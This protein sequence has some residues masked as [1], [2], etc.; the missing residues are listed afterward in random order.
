MFDYTT[1]LP[2]MEDYLKVRIAYGED[3]TGWAAQLDGEY[4]C[5]ANLP[6]RGG[7]MLYDIV[8]LDRT[9]EGLPAVAE[10]V[11]HYFAQQCCVEY[12]PQAEQDDAAACTASYAR[13]RAACVAAGCAVE[14][15]VRGIAMLNAPAGLDV[16]GLLDS[17][18]IPAEAMDVYRAE[19]EDNGDA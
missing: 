12:M 14:G 9:Q 4:V 8:T 2:H 3:E 18:G 19:E 17:L 11:Q 15:L 5:L 10:V 16:V 1:L 13:F 6:L 7:L